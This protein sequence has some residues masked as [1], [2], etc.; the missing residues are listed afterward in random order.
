MRGYKNIKVTGEEVLD[1]AYQPGKCNKI[2]RVVALRKKI[3]TEQQDLPLFENYRYFFYITNDWEL[4]SIEVVQ[5]ANQRCNQENLNSQLKSDVHALRAPLDSLE[6]NW[7]YM[8]MTSL[9]L[10]LKQWY[11]LLI[12]VEGCNP[13]EQRVLKNKILRMDFRRFI[14]G[15]IAIPVQIIRTGRR[16]IYR[17]LS[18]NPYLEVFMRTAEILRQ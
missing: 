13:R 6:S 4:S 18:W 17:I 12:P 15:L 3:V 10:I 1:F 11:A 14:N 9:A 16:I 2:Y 8:V 7:A 5:E